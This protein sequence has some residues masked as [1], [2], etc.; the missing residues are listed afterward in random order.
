METLTEMIQALGKRLS[1]LTDQDKRKLD[2]A[3]R[4][5][6]RIREIVA[7][8]HD[9][10]PHND[11]SKKMNSTKAIVKDIRK[12]VMVIQKN[13]DP[14]VIGISMSEKETGRDTAI[15]V[16]EENKKCEKPLSVCTILTGILRHVAEQSC[17]SIWYKEIINGKEYAFVVGLAEDIILNGNPLPQINYDKVNK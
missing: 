3:T 13:T 2:C 7:P 1:N 15:R 4:E 10:K 16:L 9:G 6:Q 11:N 8:I 14:V 12:R 17:S 5:L